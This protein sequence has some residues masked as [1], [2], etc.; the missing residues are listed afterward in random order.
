MTLSPNSKTILEINIFGVPDTM[1]YTNQFVLDIK[2]IVTILYWTMT[3]RPLISRLGKDVE[4]DTD[5]KMWWNRTS[6]YHRNSE[7]SQT[8]RMNTK[9]REYITEQ[10][11]D[12][13][14]HP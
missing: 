3:D 11:G 12:T 6:F 7:L 10:H 14:K 9:E 4:S 2:Q 8:R 1:S 13:F 5:R